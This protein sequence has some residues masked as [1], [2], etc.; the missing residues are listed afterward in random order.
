M[1][2][3]FIKSLSESS[4]IRSED[5]LSKF[6]ARDVADFIFL[7]FMA[8]QILRSEFESAPYAISYAEKTLAPGNI[9]NFRNTGTDLF[10]LMYTLFGKNNESAF[11]NLDNQVASI[12]L[13]KT[14]GFD[15]SQARRWLGSVARGGPEDTS[16]RQFLL[17]LETMLQIKTSD[18]KSAR[19]LIVDWSSLEQQERQLVMTRILLAFRTRL[20]RS[21]ILPEL[22]RIAKINRLEIP[23]VKNPEKDKPSKD[24]LKGAAI[25]SVIGGLLIARSVKNFVKNAGK[26]K[27]FNEGEEEEV[28]E[29]AAPGSTSAGGIAS[30]PSPIFS[31]PLRRGSKK[32]TSKIDK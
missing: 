21:E 26:I 25:G 22:E 19:R 20:P 16:G 29:N 4:L 27:K 17:K 15:W 2:F 24:L 3:D 13:L 18:Y 11:K 1:S 14:L 12:A 6:T 10:L 7:Y 28:E 5:S 9:D 30:V 8:L 31:E 23:G 32:K